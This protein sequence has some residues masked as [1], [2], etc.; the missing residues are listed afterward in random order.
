MF[1]KYPNESQCRRA[2]R[3][4]RRVPQNVQ[5]FKTIK[6]LLAPSSTLYNNHLLGAKCKLMMAKIGYVQRGSG[7]DK[8]EVRWKFCVS[9]NNSLHLRVKLDTKMLARIFTPF[10]VFDV[11]KYL[12]S[13]ANISV[14]VY[15][16][17]PC[18]KDWICLRFYRFWQYSLIMREYAKYYLI[19]C[20]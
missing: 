11:N 13:S 15:R 18:R 5:D 12:H 14:C 20:I 2:S 3:A 16:W 6:C 1:A 19:R 8:I 4:D 17:I 10:P 9:A 7:S